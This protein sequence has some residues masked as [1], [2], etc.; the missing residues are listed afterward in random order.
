[1]GSTICM[2]TGITNMFKIVNGFLDTPDSASGALDSGGSECLTVAPKSRNDE[3]TAALHGAWAARVRASMDKA[4]VSG[5]RVA[6]A[7][8]I[9]PQVVSDWRAGRSLPSVENLIA[10]SAL[11]KEPVSFLIGDRLHGKNT[12]ES[13]SRALGTRLGGARLRALAEV[14]DGDL[15]DAIDL[16]LGRQISQGKTRRK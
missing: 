12:F 3:T 11:V 13:L 1:M 4:G 10:F 7:C 6:K 9:S 14:S 2:S 8:G 5:R 16:L 15:K